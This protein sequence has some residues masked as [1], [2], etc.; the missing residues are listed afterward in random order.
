MERLSGRDLQGVL[1]FLRD[2]YA[3]RDLQAFSEHLLRALPKLVPSEITTYNEV[4]PRRSRVVWTGHPEGWDFA[5]AHGVFE[6]HMT[7]HPLIAYSRGNHGHGAIKVS[8]FLTQRQF[9]R[10]GLYNEFFRRL[11]LRHQM[12]LTLPAPPPLVIGIALNRSRQDFSERDR[13][14]L[15]LLQPHLAQAYRNSAALSELE[16]DLRLLRRG[17]EGL[18]R[19]V[20][21]L[22]RE[23]RVQAMTAAARRWLDAYFGWSAP[24]GRSVPEAIQRWMRHR[25][26]QAR[27]ETALAAPSAPLVMERDGRRLILRLV[28]DSNGAILLLEERR[29]GAEL[30]PLQSLGLTPR[31]AEVLAWV[32]QGKTNAEVG[33]ILGMSLRTVAKHLEHVYAKL[34][35]ETRTAA[36][37]R[38][39]GVLAGDG[40]WNG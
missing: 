30:A 1:D 10:L 7:E 8:D 32:A 34:G 20:V 11:H 4:N 37:A 14:V 3:L 12:A 21:L 38:A 31:E 26:E 25:E 2:V 39:L 13:R 9:H 17:V 5:G 29:Q 23:G 24:G 35:V 27:S 16:R 22:T 19:G 15:D 33:Q 6:E 36:A 28:P 18:G 40:T